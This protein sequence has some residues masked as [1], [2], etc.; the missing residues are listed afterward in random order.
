MKNSKQPVES[1]IDSFITNISFSVNLLMWNA[2]ES[3]KGN[4][5]LDWLEQTL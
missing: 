5:K 2:G 4:Y 3:L 1:F